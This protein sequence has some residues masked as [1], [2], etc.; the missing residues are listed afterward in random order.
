MRGLAAAA[1][2]E[3]RVAGSFP[4]ERGERFVLVAEHLLQ[5]YRG[6]LAEEGQ[7]RVLLHEGQ[8][9]VGLGVGGARAAGL[10]PGVAGGQGLVP[11]HAD[12][13]E[14]AVQYLLLHLVGVC[15]APVGRSHPYSIEQVVVRVREARRACCRWFCCLA[16]R[17]TGFLPGLKAGDPPEVMVNTA[18][19]P[20][21]AA[22]APNTG[23]SLAAPRC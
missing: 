20:R 16:S 9:G 1:G 21:V 4:E 11:D 23:S 12:A 3:P 13:A 6:D 2:L 7:A 22:T 19:V 18:G 8:R 14:G 15:P 5:R 17:G 10:P